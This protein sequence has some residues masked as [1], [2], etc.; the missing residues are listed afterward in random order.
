[1]ILN[2]DAN[3]ENTK[4]VGDAKRE[5]EQYGKPNQQKH[6][7]VIADETKTKEKKKENQGDRTAKEDKNYKNTSKTSKPETF[8]IT[9]G[10]FRG[11]KKRTQIKRRRTNRKL[12]TTKR[13]LY[14]ERHRNK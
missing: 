13:R 7:K 14:R 5:D 10:K 4:S 9:S 11:Q 1:M 2:K 6:Q 8:Q 3:I 12:K